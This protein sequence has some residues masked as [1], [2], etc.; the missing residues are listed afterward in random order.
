MVAPGL[1][2][3]RKNKSEKMLRIFSEGGLVTSLRS[4]DLK[5]PPVRPPRVPPKSFCRIA[6]CGCPARLVN[7]SLAS[8][9]LFR[10]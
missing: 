1:Q 3:I 2:R 9:K 4:S 10:R 7:Q 5:T 8:K 6:G